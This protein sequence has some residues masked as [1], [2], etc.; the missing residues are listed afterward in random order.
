MSSLA[1]VRPAESFAERVRSLVES[2]DYRLAVTD[3]E[4]E[5]IYRLRYQG[6]LA[7]KAI[8]ANF[9]RRLSDKF[10]DL[11]NSWLFGVFIEGAL[12]SSIRITIANSSHPQ[13]PALETFGDALQG[14]VAAEKIIVDPTRFVIDR[15]M[16]RR[17]PDLRFATTRLAV[18]AAEYFNADLLLASVRT[19]H[20]PFYQRTFGHIVVCTARTYPTLIKPLSL[21]VADFARK[22]HIMMAR[23][24][25]FRSTFFERRMAFEPGALQ[26]IDAAPDSRLQPSSQALAS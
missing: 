15:L 9:G 23:F 4:K 25:F 8:A 19:E 22:R 24:P 11:D 21:M 13:S 26:H 20:Q 6:Y 5:A 2:V 12:A 10:D 3:A 7:E 16:S 1:Y 18:M 17:F 14:A